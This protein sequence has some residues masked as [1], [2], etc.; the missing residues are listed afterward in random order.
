MTSSLKMPTW[1]YVVMKCLVILA[2][3]FGLKIQFWDQ[4][5]PDLAEMRPFGAT[6]AGW[7]A[8]DVQVKEVLGVFGITAYIEAMYMGTTFCRLLTFLHSEFQKQ[9]EHAQQ[10]YEEE[11]PLI[12]EAAQRFQLH[13]YW[14]KH[15]KV[16]SMDNS[17]TE[18]LTRRVRSMRIQLEEEGREDHR[19]EKDKCDMLQWLE[20]NG[21]P[22]PKVVGIWHGNVELFLKELF[23]RVTLSGNST[24]PLFAKTCHLTQG[25][26]DSVRMLK[27]PE[28]VLEHKQDLTA[29][30]EQKW[31]KTTKDKDR[32]FAA[33]SNTLSR[34][35]PPG[36]VIQEAFPRPVE[37]KVLVLWGRA[38]I[39]YVIES[40][41]IVCRDATFEK[42]S[43]ARGWGSNAPV[44][45]S[46]VPELAWVEEQLPRIWQLS[47]AVA[48]ASGNEQIR[49]DIF[50]RKGEPDAISVNEI[51]LSSGT[52]QHMH[53]EFVAK[54]WAEPH[55]K[56]S[57][58]SH[59]SKLPVHKLDVTSDEMPNS[60]A[61]WSALQSAIGR[62]G[63]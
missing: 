62:G 1:M 45:I 23:S 18:L 17:W 16:D 20:R 6:A 29:F 2:F 35:L 14:S 44:P 55:I 27:S 60:E 53:T 52:L 11:R 9:H 21:F 7:S 58:Q 54:L 33:D 26:E 5:A 19:L 40:Q 34:F 25:V 39:A 57:Y 46:Q 24:W 28:W 49:V 4:N 36:F 50:V 38:Y 30:V 56:A 15:M 13:G 61:F 48:L 47:E 43:R 42:G 3:L 51:S 10:Y 59:P 41:G 37:F 31:K 32:I 12:M 8:V 22:I 63:T